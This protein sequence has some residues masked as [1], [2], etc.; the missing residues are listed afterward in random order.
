MRER[1]QSDPN[2]KHLNTNHLTLE[3]LTRGEARLK[4]MPISFE[5]VLL[6]TPISNGQTT[7]AHPEPVSGPPPLA[8]AGVAGQ[9]SGVVHPAPHPV[10]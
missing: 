9:G 6:K 4:A 10:P 7:Q 1:L 5:K 3:Y 2:T 8:G